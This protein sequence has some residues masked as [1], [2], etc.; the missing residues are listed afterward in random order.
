MTT[1]EATPKIRITLR[2]ATPEIER[3]LWEL[4]GQRPTNIDGLVA[5]LLDVDVAERVVSWLKE[6]NVDR[7]TCS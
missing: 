2:S 7:G 6:H 5:L 4:T 3:R 1:F